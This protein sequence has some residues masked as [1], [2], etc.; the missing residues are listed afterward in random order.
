MEVVGPDIRFPGEGIDIPPLGSSAVKDIEDL[1]DGFKNEPCFRWNFAWKVCEHC[2]GDMIL[3]AG[4]SKERLPLLK[5]SITSCV[6][7]PDQIT[8][9]APDSKILATCDP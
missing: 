9:I 3:T 1:L 6:A 8:N 4:K 5:K 7:P 2:E